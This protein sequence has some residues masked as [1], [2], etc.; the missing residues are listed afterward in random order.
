MTI[1]EVNR[2]LHVGTLPITIS[3]QI[4]YGGIYRFVRITTDNRVFLDYD[5]EFDDFDGLRITFC[6]DSIEKMIRSIE[7]YLGHGIEKCLRVFENDLPEINS[8]AD[9]Y[10]LKTDLYNGDILMLKGYTEMYIGSM[11][12]KGLYS[13][14]ITPDSSID[15]LDEWIRS[16]M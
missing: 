14:N 13:R 9:W 2:I 11:Y 16:N 3:A 7:E 12:W 5:E 10:S 8:S 6:F 4:E 1:D 15:E